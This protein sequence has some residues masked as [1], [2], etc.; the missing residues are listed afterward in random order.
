MRYN[1][2]LVTG[3]ILLATGIL[4]VGA[5]EVRVDIARTTEYIYVPIYNFKPPG[6]YTINTT[7]IID[8]LAQSITLNETPRKMTRE[9]QP[10][11][12][13][14]GIR[15]INVKAEGV[16]EKAHGYILVKI[17]AGFPDGSNTTIA[18]Y[19]LEVKPLPAPEAPDTS[20]ATPLVVNGTVTV[21]YVSVLSPSGRED[22]VIYPI[23]RELPLNTTKLT[24]LFDSN[25]TGELMAGVEVKEVC[26][27]PFHADSP[28]LMPAGTSAQRITV[29]STV[30]IDTSRL[31]LGLAIALTG[32]L[33]SILGIYQEVAGSR[34]KV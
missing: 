18:D 23:K 9:L 20:T 29:P 33:L 4:T 21:G 24:L 1:I 19:H 3:A 30:K 27:K 12:C 22:I 7:K 34:E 5:S 11:S 32:N 14:K 2:L 25:L 31:R 15:E 13:N 6:N 16:A 28:F 26:M 17:I 10:P 8:R